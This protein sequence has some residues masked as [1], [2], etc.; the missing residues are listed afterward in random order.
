VVI[1]IVLFSISVCFELV[2]LPILK[3]KGKAP[4]EDECAMFELGMFMLMASCILSGD[5]I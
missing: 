1:S 2:V 5:W 3:K 4:S